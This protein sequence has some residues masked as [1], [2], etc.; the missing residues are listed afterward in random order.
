[1][2]PTVVRAVAAGV[3]GEANTLAAQRTMVS[4][5]MARLM[6]DIPGCFF[7]VG[8]MNSARGLDFP[9]HNPRFD[10]DEAA[11]PIGVAVLAGAAASYVLAE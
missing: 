1:M 7:F 4:E 3:V 5:D 8:T 10:I 6:D 9:H 2:D 11:L